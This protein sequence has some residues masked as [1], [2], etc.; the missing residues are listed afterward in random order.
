MYTLFPVIDVFIKAW[1]IPQMF[2][3]EI[4]ISSGVPNKPI[5]QMIRQN[6]EIKVFKLKKGNKIKS[7]SKSAFFAIFQ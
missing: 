7:F 2:Q 1:S 6:I 3:H 5:F 4:Y